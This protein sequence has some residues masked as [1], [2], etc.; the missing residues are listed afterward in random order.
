MGGAVIQTQT[1][2]NNNIFVVSGRLYSGIAM[3]F[4]TLLLSAPRASAAFFKLPTRA[5]T[6]VV[7]IRQSYKIKCIWFRL[8][9]F[10]NQSYRSDLQNSYLKLKKSSANQHSPNPQNW[11]PY[12][13]P[14]LIQGLKP[15]CD[16]TFAKPESF[17]Q[18]SLRNLIKLFNRSQG[19]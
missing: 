15:A 16:E 2:P 9:Q 13:D 7:S 4:T 8:L 1:L 12:F 5:V 17:T 3:F 19:C 18:K 6:T 10:V 14:P 11:S